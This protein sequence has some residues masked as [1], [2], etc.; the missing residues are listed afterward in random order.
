MGYSDN[1]SQLPTSYLLNEI[2]RHEQEIAN[3]IREM[4]MVREALAE[5]EIQLQS[6]MGSL[7][8]LHDVSI[9]DI[10]AD[11]ASGMLT[12]V[13]GMEA[14]RWYRDRC[15]RIAIEHGFWGNSIKENMTIVPDLVASETIGMKLMLVVT[16]LA[17]WMEA[18]RHGDPASDHIPEFKTSE[19]EAADVLIRVFDLAGALGLRLSE[20]LEAKIT[21][22]RGREYMHGKTC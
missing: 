17:E 18:V 3:H 12:M 13:S 21:Y 14:M 22:N 1:L 6:K 4:K 16:E 7:D 15:H 11:P 5:K 10:P 2:S 8:S 9:V 19:E 20:A